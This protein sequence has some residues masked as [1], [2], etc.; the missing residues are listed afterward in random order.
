MQTIEAHRDKFIDLVRACN[1]TGCLEYIAKYDDFYDAIIDN[2]SRPN[3][4]QMVCANKLSKVAVALID[5]KCN[6]TYQNSYGFTALMYANCYE[7]KDIVTYIIDKSMDCTTR[8]TT[9]DELSEMMYLCDYRHDVKNIIKMIDCGYNIYYKNKYHR[10]LFMVAIDNC[11]EQVV[12]K[13]VDIDTCFIDEFKQYYDTETDTDR[14]KNP[15]FDMTIMKYCVDKRDTIKREIITTMNYA[16]P[17]NML[18][19][20]FH[21]TYAV[22]LVDVICDFI[23]LP[24]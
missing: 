17:T 18:Y 5:R 3:M 2:G 7:L 23:L 12:K 11:L 14:F 19:Q 13:L 4:L 16:S 6:L 10:S 8:I 22:E 21:T 9:Y 15:K 1:E 24:I 20:S